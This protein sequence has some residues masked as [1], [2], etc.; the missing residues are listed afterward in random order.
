MGTPAFEY[1]DTHCHLW[2]IDL[3]KKWLGADW[4]GMYRT[5]RPADIATVSKPFGVTSAIAIECGLSEEENEALRRVADE[6][7]YIRG[8]A[9]HVD[10]ESPDLEG[11][12]S[13]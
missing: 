2:E 7:S 4:P 3:A 12:L 1:V 9:P 5:F 10:L 13:K 6:S 8:Y 11:I